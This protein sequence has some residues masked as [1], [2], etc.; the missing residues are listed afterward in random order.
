MKLSRPLAAAAALALVAASSLGLAGA[1]SAATPGVTYVTATDIAVTPTPG[2]P[3]WS[4]E[5]GTATSGLS[6]L[7]VTAGSHLQYAFSTAKD[8]TTGSALEDISSPDPITFDTSVAGGE[9]PEFDLFKDGV[10][11]LVVI[12]RTSPGTD[13]ADTGA[14]WESN[15]TIGS[16]T[17]NTPATLANFD[18]QLAAD[19]TFS[20][21]TF[22]AVELYTP[23]ADT[24]RDADILGTQYIF[25]PQPVFTAPT[26]IP[27]ASYQ[28]SPGVTITTNGFLPNSGVDVGY[29]KL[30]G[31]FSLLTTLTADSIGSITFSHWDPTAV[32]G[33]YTL[34]FA[35]SVP[36]PQSFDFTATAPTL[37]ATGVAPVTPLLIATGCLV[38]GFLLAVI[39][40]RRRSRTS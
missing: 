37:A 20:A 10:S 36:N 5:A 34:E 7:A 29:S 1:A 4:I 27:V 18:A 8:A 35:G 16:I 26:T 17:N 25:T 13:F 30:G 2:T 23:N 28:T 3:G 6:G 33:A 22:F 32:P 24:Y 38:G 19:L 40:T 21:A 11:A 15:T 39:A 9:Y 12:F 14:V 31:P